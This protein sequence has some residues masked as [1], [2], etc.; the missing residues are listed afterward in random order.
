MKNTY[1]EST[2]FTKILII[3]LPFSSNYIKIE[4]RGETN[5]TKLRSNCT[6]QE[7]SLFRTILFLISK[8]GVNYMMN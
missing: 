6:L 4:A 2:A 1:V 7:N 8:Y 3:P 5:S